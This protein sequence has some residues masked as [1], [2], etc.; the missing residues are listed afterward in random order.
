MGKFEERIFIV[1]KIS[2]KELKNLQVDILKYVHAFCMAN[3][4]VYWLDFGTLLGAIRHNGYIPWDDD[5]DIGMLRKDYDRFMELFYDDS[6]RYRFV[7]AENDDEYS[8]AA[9]K[10]VDTQTVLYEP[11]ETGFKTAV[12]IDVFVHD[13]APDSER[14]VD[15]MYKKREFFSYLNI[16]RIHSKSIRTSLTRRAIFKIIHICIKGVPYNFF[17]KK[18]IANSKKYSE[19][20]TERIGNF[21]GVSKFTCSRE[22]VSK[23]ID[24]NFEGELFKI[25][26]RYDEWLRL[27]YGDYMKLPSVENRVS[28]HMYK[29]YYID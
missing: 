27:S 20:K 18:M 13:N 28:H 16:A 14:E 15:K 9:G 19:V 24:H 11:D 4:I 7:C 22:L 17:A 1:K 26:C 10:V 23:V 2:E 5:I 29:A 21:V 8:L 6:S 12:Y 3:N 25:P